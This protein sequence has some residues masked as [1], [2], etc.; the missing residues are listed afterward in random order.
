MSAE[1]RDTQAAQR[2]FLAN[3]SH[4]LKTPLTSIQG[5]SDVLRKFPVSAEESKEMVETIHSEAVRLNEII[6]RF[7]DVKRL[8]SGAQ[9]LQISEVNIEKLI[10]D[11]I[12][13]AAPLAAEK[14]IEIQNRAK[15]S[16][17]L[18][19]ADSQLLAQA[20]GNLL[21]NAVKYSPP[22]S[23]VAVE[24]VKNDSELQIIVRDNGYGIPENAQ[25]RIF[26]KFY[27][28]E[29]DASS[30]TVGT[31]LG[32]TFVK[33]VAEKHGGR[34]SVESRQNIGSA[35]VLHLPL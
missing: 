8:E 7:L 19:Q 11:C 22:E 1:V 26:E 3:V 14:N 33:E 28:L 10:A 21:S 13:A 27:R 20:V 5:L 18:L 25:A 32:L 6:N 23:I 35:F 12:A 24:A 2:D 15:S 16:L 17:P 31:G 29:R 4:D 30:E 9:D 34:V